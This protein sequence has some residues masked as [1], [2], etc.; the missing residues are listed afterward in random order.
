LQ[1]AAGRDGPERIRV[2]VPLGAVAVVSG[3]ASPKRFFKLIPSG[4]KS[5]PQLPMTW[6]MVADARL[7]RMRYP[8]ECLVCAR[9]LERGAHAW[10]NDERRFVTCVECSGVADDPDFNPPDLMH[11][12]GFAN[13]N[14]KRD[15]LRDLKD[16]DNS[17]R[18]AYADLGRMIWDVSH[19]RTSPKVWGVDAGGKSIVGEMLDPLVDHGMIVLHDV[20][21]PSER[22]KVDHIVVAPSGIHVIDSR[23]F[24][25]QRV[26]IRKDKRFIGHSSSLY[27]GG[28]DFTHLIE[29]MGHQVRR[30]YAFTNDLPSAYNTNVTPVLCFVDA[31][32]RWARKRLALGNVEI[33]WPKV[34]LRLLSRPG[35]LS[36]DDIEAIGCRLASRLVYDFND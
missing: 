33:L 14:F 26:E 15:Q 28:R 6:L 29:N 8:G 19:A 4:D 24:R 27:V 35:S 18:N 21:M 11:R 36:R 13:E 17:I 10:W 12:T 5:A 3:P 9:D 2:D 7:I 34:L 1:G 23:S 31:Q 20:R 30:V 25:G 22:N 16:S 32:W